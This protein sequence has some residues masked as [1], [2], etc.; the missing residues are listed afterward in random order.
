MEGQK[1]EEMNPDKGIACTPWLE[2][3]KCYDRTMA[4]GR[5]RHVA[6]DGAGEEAWVRS[7]RAL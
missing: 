7:Q 5:S 4:V 3:K 6:G 2:E 1:R